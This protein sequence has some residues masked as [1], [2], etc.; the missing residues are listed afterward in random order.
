MLEFESQFDLETP[1]DQHIE[2]TRKKT[3]HKNAK[4]SWFSQPNS[5]YVYGTQQ[6]SL[7]YIMFIREQIISL[8]S[9]HLSTLMAYKYN[10]SSH[11]RVCVH[12]CV[13]TW[14]CVQL[15]MCACCACVLHV[16]EGVCAHVCACVCVCI[17]P[18]PE[19]RI[20]HI[21]RTS[22]AIDGKQPLGDLTLDAPQLG[23]CI[24]ACVDANFVVQPKLCVK[25]KNVSLNTFPP[26][27]H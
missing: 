21:A 18:E 4:N 26:Y 15:H 7:Q 2:H 12:A 9:L 20:P 1:R 19:N 3:N 27:I 6:F 13:C 24:C 23:L 5:T 8:I 16:R 25:S 10:L 22:F 17:T 11:T 14:V